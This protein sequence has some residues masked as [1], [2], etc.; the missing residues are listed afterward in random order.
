MVGG[1][2]GDAAMVG[3]WCSGGAAMVAAVGVLD[4]LVLPLPSFLFT[5][6]AFCG[7][8]CPLLQRHGS[9]TF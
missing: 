9:R 7:D 8:S 4:L 5:L 1:C 2:S 3:S 6:T